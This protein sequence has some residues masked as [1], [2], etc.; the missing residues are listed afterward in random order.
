MQVLSSL[1][2]SKE[3][4]LTSSD[5]SLGPKGIARLRAPFPQIIRDQHD[6]PYL[7]AKR[8]LNERAREDALLQ[9]KGATQPNNPVGDNTHFVP[10]TGATVGDA[11]A[12][13]A[14]DLALDGD[15]STESDIDLNDVNPADLVDNDIDFD[16]IQ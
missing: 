6:T 5:N 10:A 12:A 1:M 14:A 2:L 16:D 9:A 8:L 15:L 3:N 4:M 11:L 7:T 13:A